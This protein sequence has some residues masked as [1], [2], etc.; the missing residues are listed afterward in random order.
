MTLQQN[1]NINSC[2][3]KDYNETTTQKKWK[4]EN[5]MINRT[6]IKSNTNNRFYQRGRDL[7]EAGKVLSLEALEEDGVV[8]VTGYV[9]GSGINIYGAMSRFSTK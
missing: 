6:D 5:H 2:N 1:N 7:Y 3:N 9:K 8:Y 4:M